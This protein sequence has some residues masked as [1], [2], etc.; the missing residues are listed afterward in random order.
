MPNNNLSIEDYISACLIL[1]DSFERIHPC[2][3]IVEDE[4]FV[5]CF[6]RQ[7]SPED[8][9]IKKDL[10]N[11]MSVEAKEIISI[12]LNAPD[13]I[14]KEIATP[15]RKQVTK[16][17]V[18]KFFSKVWISEFIAEYTIRDISKWANQL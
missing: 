13:E 10:Y 6:S 12:I 1:A 16:K 18:K 15:K 7:P 8:I 17:R 3:A 11:K 14:L 5:S 2:D 9:V 4:D